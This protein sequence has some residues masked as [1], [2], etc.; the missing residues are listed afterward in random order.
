MKLKQHTLK[1]VTVKW[2]LADIHNITRSRLLGFPWKGTEAGNFQTGG[3]KVT[4]K[5]S[6]KQF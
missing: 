6:Y 5:L 2:I 4:F 3:E 1:G